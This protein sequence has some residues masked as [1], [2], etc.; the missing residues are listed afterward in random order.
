MQNSPKFICNSAFVCRDCVRVT[1]CGFRLGVAQPIQP[2]RHR[3][4][5]LI[6]Q[7]GVAMPKSVETTLRDPQLLE[8]GM[9]FALAYQAVI[10]RSAV[11]SGKQQSS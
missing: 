11:L 2:D 7:C 9:E 6:E 1:H 5:D 4:P 10:P 8:Q 3:C